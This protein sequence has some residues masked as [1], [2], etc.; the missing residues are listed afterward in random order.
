MNFFCTKNHYDL[1]S[2][3]NGINE[4]EVFCLDAYE[5]LIVAEML[6]SV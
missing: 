6:F 5:A 4:D 1:W 3:Y 2:A